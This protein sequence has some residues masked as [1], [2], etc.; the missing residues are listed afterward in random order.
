MPIGCCSTSKQYGSD[1]R[2]VEG[3]ISIAK[4]Y[5]SDSVPQGKA[6]LRIHVY[7]KYDVKEATTFVVHIY[8]EAIKG[9]I[10][11]L[12]NGSSTYETDIPNGECEV[13]VWSGGKVYGQTLKNFMVNSGEIIE[14]NVEL[15]GVGIY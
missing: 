7:D 3:S 9:M 5:T 8:G 6:R 11:K 14:I 12:H 10:R 1:Y 4:R 2:V 15:G 13:F